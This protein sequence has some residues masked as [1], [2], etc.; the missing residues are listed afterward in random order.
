M[1]KKISFLT[2][3]VFLGTSLLLPQEEEKKTP[4]P[5]RHEVVVTATRVETPVKEAAGSVTVVT[6]DD[7]WK[8]KKTT[9]LEALSEILGI[10][11]VQS[12]GMGGAASV[13]LRGANSEH[14]LIMLDGVELNDP[15]S[16][17]R[18]YDL[19]HFPID[20]I[21]R[22]EIMRGPQSTLYGSDAIGGLINIVTRK[23]EGRPKITL[24]AGG[25]SH[26]TMANH[27]QAG[28][29]GKV[30]N[31]SLGLAH[32][33]T[34][35]ISA[36]AADYRGNTEKDGYR[37]LALSARLGLN[38]KQNMELDLIL[39][40][41]DAR[42]DIDNFG[43]DYGDDPNSL[44]EYCSLFL[45][46]QFRTLSLSNRLEQ[47]LGI[48]YIRSRRDHKNPEDFSHPFD[49]EEGYFRSGLFKADWQ[50]N[51]FLH[52]SHTLTAGLEYELEQGE[53]EYHSR[54]MW[55][56]FTSLFPHRNSKSLGVYLQDRIRL[57]GRFFATAGVR[58]DRHSRSGWSLTYRLAP[59][60]FIE[61]TRTRLKANLG[62][63]FKSPSL[64]QLYAPASL[65]G[66]VGNSRLLPEKSLSWEAGIEQELAGGKVLLGGLYFSNE[67][68]NLIDFDFRH[69]YINIGE[70]YTRGVELLA[71]M[72]PAAGFSL[73]TNFARMDARDRR[74]RLRLLRRPRQK[75]AATLDYSFLHRWQVSISFL[76]TG[77]REDMDFSAWPAA[78]V[79]L[80][81]YNLMNASLSFDLSSHIQLF[82][83]FDNIFNARYEM[84]KGYGTLGFTALAGARLSF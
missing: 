7:L 27:L 78:R 29:G 35:G 11:A 82:G 83:R 9:V 63:G 77:E 43:G 55:G 48:A 52:S 18:S 28:G 13:F 14:T 20:N 47:K 6:S 38:L 16:P 5:L 54:G 76:H 12:G 24:T 81:S 22:I 57:G 74:S 79:I 26:G 62:T 59:A 25:G 67:F 56:P 53:S 45:K 60:Y 19:A 80:P 68:R 69:G 30:M 46:G 44:Q 72:R 1:Y 73:K 31:Y 58:L 21:E 42:T 36:A 64:Y 66:P 49:S 70:S 40:G 8:S 10:S 41:L 51:L 17:S 4:P 39:R 50:N 37:N 32:F 33:Q 2:L 34:H 15:I 84:I 23:G 61:G 3:A 75:F 65:W 71:E